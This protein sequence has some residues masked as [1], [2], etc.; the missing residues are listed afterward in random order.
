MESD[1]RMR[2]FP[3]NIRSGERYR[4]AMCVRNCVLNHSPRIFVLLYTDKMEDFND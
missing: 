2:A 3:V 1:L 4:T